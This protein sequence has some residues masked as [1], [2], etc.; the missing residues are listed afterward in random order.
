MGLREHLSSKLQ[1]FEHAINT[2]RQAP[3]FPK[4][5]GLTLAVA[6]LAGTSMLPNGLFAQETPQDQIIY[7]SDKGLRVE[8]SCLNPHQNR[9]VIDGTA[10]NLAPDAYSVT[11]ADEETGVIQLYLLGQGSENLKF[12]TPPAE[13]MGE[14]TRPLIEGHIYD[15]SVYGSSGLVDKIAVG[16]FCQPAS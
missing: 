8:V 6:C 2:F 9:F 5:A 11:I 15:V 7:T 14:P 13:A 3:R 10:M 12:S 4:R 16:K 1:T